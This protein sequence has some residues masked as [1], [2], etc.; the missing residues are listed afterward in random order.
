MLLSIS[1]VHPE[2]DGKAIREQKDANEAFF[3]QRIPSMDILSG[4]V[5]PP[6]AAS[7]LFA[8]PLQPLALWSCSHVALF[9]GTTLSKRPNRWTNPACRNK[10]MSRTRSPAP[11]PSTP[12]SRRALQ[13][14]PGL[15]IRQD[16]LARRGRVRKGTISVGKGTAQTRRGAR[17]AARERR[18]RCLTKAR[19][20]IELRFDTWACLSVRS[21]RLFAMY[22]CQRSFAQHKHRGFG[23]CD[24][25]TP[26]CALAS[27]GSEFAPPAFRLF[28][29]ACRSTALKPLSDS[30]LPL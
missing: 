28:L 18:R 25:E 19:S 4:K 6:E 21:V 8:S 7:A 1:R 9:P 3:G 22:E 15:L 12:P 13:A 17:R 14:R 24:G 2:A 10:P 27:I 5:P 30:N 16:R 26:D 20:C 23:H 11:T 29:L